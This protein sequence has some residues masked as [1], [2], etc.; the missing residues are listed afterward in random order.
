VWSGENRRLRFGSAPILSPSALLS[1]AAALAQWKIW[2]RVQ[3]DFMDLRIQPSQEVDEWLGEFG[4]G[5][6]TVP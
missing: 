5:D 1:N 3:A 2:A 6:D 4:F